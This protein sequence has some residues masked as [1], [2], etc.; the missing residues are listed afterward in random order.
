MLSAALLLGALRFFRL[1]EWSLWHDEALSLHEAL[2][3]LAGEY[4]ALPSHALGVASIA[5]LLQLTGSQW[6]SEWLLRI[7]PACAGWAGIALT[8]W[9]LRP[10]GRPKRA[11]FAA[12]ILASSSWHLYWSQCAR[13]YTLAQDLSLLGCGLFL[14]GLLHGKSAKMVAGLVLALLAASFHLSALFAVGGL[15]LGPLAARPW[16]RTTTEEEQHRSS[17]RTY[18]LLGRIA[19]G[20][21]VATAIAAWRPWLEYASKKEAAPLSGLTHFALTTGF[22]ATPLLAT[23]AGLGALLALRSRWGSDMLA[24]AVTAIGLLTALIASLFA[25]VTAQYVFVLL[26]WIAYLASAPLE[27]GEEPG[28]DMN[29]DGGKSR[30]G[31]PGRSAPIASWCYA[32]V[33]VL[34]PLADI[35]LYFTEHNGARPMLREAYQYVWNHRASEDL[36]FGM[37][38]PVGEYY[39]NP[40]TR[41]LRRTV[42]V[43]R[44]DAYHAEGPAEWTRYG[45]RAWF[46]IRGEW[47]KS[48]WPGDR[49]RLVALLGEQ[50]RLVQSYPLYVGARDL[51]VLVYVR[52]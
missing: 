6:P 26:P 29:R 50:C 48:L 39:L 40:G 42:A 15:V 4:G 13:F 7:V 38:T 5:A 14:R 46:V 23:G 3:L 21:I 43:A 27:A 30:S 8:Y 41:D 33:L 36:I 20:A 19:I 24:L 51:S 16:A 9:A 32:L 34:P 17:E 11:A 45:R 44:L 47:I 31:S 28:A 22:F 12:L 52:D 1:G 18:V 10:L 37:E 2:R 49:E 25:I 35:G